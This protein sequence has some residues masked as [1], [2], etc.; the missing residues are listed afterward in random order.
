[1]KVDPKQFE[2]FYW[3]IYDLEMK[4]TGDIGKLIADFLPE[5]IKAL[6]VEY[7]NDMARYFCRDHEGHKK[8]LGVPGFVLNTKLGSDWELDN[9]LLA[10]P[11]ED[12]FTTHL[13]VEV[14]RSLT[15]ERDPKDIAN[16]IFKKRNELIDIFKGMINTLENLTVTVEDEGNG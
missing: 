11:V 8:Y 2:D 15:L 5:F 4:V 9:A 6:E 13:Q 7:T 1:M 16:I 3:P 10:L 12:I 14:E